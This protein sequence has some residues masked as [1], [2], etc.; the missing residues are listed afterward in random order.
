MVFPP[1]EKEEKK[2]KMVKVL[3]LLQKNYPDAKTALEYKKPHELLISTILSA[4]CTDKRVNIVTKDLF[5]KYKT[6]KDFAFS[7]LAEL[8]KDIH[9]TG[10]YKNKAKNIKGCCQMLMQKYGGEV[11][12][13][14]EALIQLSGVGRKTANVILP[15]IFGKNEGVCVDT[16]MI[17]LSQRI[18]FS[19]H[20]D[21]VKIE[22]DLMEITPQKDWMVVTNLLIYHGRVICHARK[23][24]CAECVIRHHCHFFRGNKKSE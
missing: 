17:R 15:N 3:S 10:F 23:P 6:I 8:E 9:S 18:G 2:E 12:D 20:K 19:K 14:M 4:Q 1:K 21:P 24:K 22:K 11:P 7:S 5:K 13:T 16:H